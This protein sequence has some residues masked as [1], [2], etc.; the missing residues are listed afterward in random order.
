M[1]LGHGFLAARAGAKN[2]LLTALCQRGGSVCDTGSTRVA[3]FV[4]T[5]G[6]GEEEIHGKPEVRNGAMLRLQD[7]VEP[8]HAA[9]CDAS[10]PFA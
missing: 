7:L 6:G 9:L 8:L 3:I 1:T 10:G 2:C 4:T 5:Q